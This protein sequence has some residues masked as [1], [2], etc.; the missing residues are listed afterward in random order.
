MSKIE[1]YNGK[2]WSLSKKTKEQLDILLADLAES[3]MDIVIVIDG[4]EGTGKSF[5]AR[6]LAMYCATL[7]RK[8]FPKT[9]FDVKDIQFDTKEYVEASLE[10]EKPGI[11]NQVKINVL[12]EGRKALNKMRRNSKSNITFTDY[13]SECRSKQQVHIIL[14]P[15]YHDLDKNLISWRTNMIIHFKKQY[16]ESSKSVSGYKLKRGEF[17]LFTDKKQIRA[18]YGM[19]YAYPY[20]YGD[21]NWWSS[22]EVF[23]DEQIK[24]YNDKKDYYTLQKYTVENDKNE[25]KSKANS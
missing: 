10:A 5:A 9:T 22:K 3:E 6:G 4:Y 17:K 8:W 16:L 1:L 13:L 19:P 14:A 18:C 15:A 20:N 2:E 24:K 21:H 25:K 23:T 12:D 11:I 7:L